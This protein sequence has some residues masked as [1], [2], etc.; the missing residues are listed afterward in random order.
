MRAKTSNANTISTTIKPVL[1]GV[2]SNA[3]T[4]NPA[5]I[6]SEIAIISKGNQSFPLHPPL[7][8][9]ALII[10]ISFPDV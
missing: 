1:Y 5:K 10:S 9:E 8:Q 7:F 4:K 2:K 6:P 3:P